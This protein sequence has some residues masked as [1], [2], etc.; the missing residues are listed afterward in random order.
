MTSVTA[1]A[2]G[3]TVKALLEESRRHLRGHCTLAELAAYHQGALSAE[4]QESVAEHLAVC[5]DCTILLLYAVAGPD[6]SEAH[7]EPPDPELEADWDQFRLHLKNRHPQWRSLASL[8]PVRR[9]PVREALPLALE[10]SRA[11]VALHSEG[12]ILTDLRAENALLSPTGQV[13]LLERGLAPPP[14]SLEVGYERSAE[15]AVIDLYRALSPE[16]IA[17]EEPSQRSNLFSLGVLLYELFT[18]ISPFRGDTPL[19]TATRILSLEPAPARE[20]NQEIDPALSD[21]LTRLLS[22]E[23]A[24]RPLSAAEVV[25]AIE[26]ALGHR[27][28]Q[29]APLGSEDLDLEGQIESLYDKLID[30]AQQQPADHGA[31]EKEIERHYDRLLE[32]QAAEAERFREQFEAGLTMPIDAGAEILDR[33]RALKEELED[34][35]PADTAAQEADDTPAPAKA[36]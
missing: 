13:R 21:L 8:P 32:L 20:I 23:P 28:A 5:E 29:S 1:R 15:A 11:L 34:L 16:Q 30:L 19:S 31:L 18:G 24:D 6:G 3:E 36:R 26:A 33:I 4:R 14:E 25:K 2:F 35:A 9:L 10:I 7:S 17:G 22:K 12:R 27:S